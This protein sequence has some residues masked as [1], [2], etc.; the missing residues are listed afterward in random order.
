MK[1]IVGADVVPLHALNGN[2]NG[3]HAANG[4]GN[5]AG[6]GE[7]VLT[8]RLTAQGL[9]K[10]LERE[11]NPCG[12]GLLVNRL[13]AVKEAQQQDEPKLLAG[14]LEDLAAAAVGYSYRVRAASGIWPKPLPKS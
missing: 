7:A 11:N 10:L 2:G 1:G 9:R 4:N 3:H 14:A 13:R 8:P 12:P 5:G 6:D